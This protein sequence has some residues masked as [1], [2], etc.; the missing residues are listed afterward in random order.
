MIYIYICIYIYIYNYLEQSLG[1]QPSCSGDYYAPVILLIAYWDSDTTFRSLGDFFPL[2]L[3]LW[4]VDC[5]W[6]IRSLLLN[7]LLRTHWLIDEPNNFR[8][9]CHEAVHGYVLGECR[10]ASWLTAFDDNFSRTP[11]FVLMI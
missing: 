3:R 6:L 2:S 10:L 8:P 1:R 4:F 11:R 5:H 9:G 7:D